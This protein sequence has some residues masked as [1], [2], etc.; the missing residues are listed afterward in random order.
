MEYDAIVVAGGRGS[1]VGGAAKVLGVIDGRTLLGRAIAACSGAR[2]V[3][4]GP[5]ELALH[6]GAATLVREDPPFGGPV[7]AIAAGCAAATEPAPWTLVL[8]ADHVDPTTAIAAVL[9]ATESAADVID[10][11]IA[12]DENDRGQYLL[13]VYRSDRIRS[14]LAALPTVDGASVRTL[15]RGMRLRAVRVEPGAARDV[16]TPEDALAARVTLP[17]A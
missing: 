11:V 2:V 14:A 7:A 12:V 16:D 17:P 13:A 10:G 5:P 9:A 1:R 6:A 4:V 3:V 15:I 8:A